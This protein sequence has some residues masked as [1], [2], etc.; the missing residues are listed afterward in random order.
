[1]WQP[2]SVL[3]LLRDAIF[4]FLLITTKAETNHFIDVSLFGALFLL[5]VFRFRILYLDIFPKYVPF[6]HSWFKNCPIIKYFYLFMVQFMKN[7]WENRYWAG[8]SSVWHNYADVTKKRS[9]LYT[10]IVAKAS[11]R[12]ICI[13]ACYC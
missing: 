6:S 11:C 10:V 2:V 13:W 5:S 3:E 8:N 9:L 1:M 4:F 7:K 12:R